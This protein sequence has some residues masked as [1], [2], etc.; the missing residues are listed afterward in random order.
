MTDETNIDAIHK[1]IGEGLIRRVGLEGRQIQSFVNE[2][3]R[4]C[5]ALNQHPMQSPDILRVLADI[6]RHC[7]NQLT[8]YEKEMEMQAFIKQESEKNG[9]K[10]V[11]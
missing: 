8:D 9:L 5:E 2:W 7:G 4:H 1:A 3:L 11:K 10:A 6:D